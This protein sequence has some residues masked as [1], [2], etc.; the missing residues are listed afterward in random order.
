MRVARLGCIGLVWLA[1][2]LASAAW[3]RCVAIGQEK[4]G[5]FAVD[6]M[7]TNVGDLPPER[8]EHLKQRL[9]SAITGLTPNASL[10]SVDCAATDDQLAAD[11]AYSRL[12][13]KQSKT[14][15]WTHLTVLTPDQ[16]LA[17]S[18]YNDGAN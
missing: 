2:H 4:S 1:P 6:T 16:W 10:T 3:L 11:H 18:D 5:P 8:L 15:G 12:W 7:V 13:T 9:R 17:D 14:F